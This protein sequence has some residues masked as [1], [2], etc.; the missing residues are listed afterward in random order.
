MENKKVAVADSLES[1]FSLPLSTSKEIKSANKKETC[2][3]KSLTEE[4]EESLAIRQISITSRALQ[5]MF[6]MAKEV[7]RLFNDSLEVYALVVGT[8]DVIED[9]II[10]SQICSHTSIHI[11]PEA[12]LSLMPEIQ[13][14]NVTVL[15]WTHSHANFGVFFSGTDSQNQ[16]TI[17]AET[18]NYM[19]LNGS[20]VKFCYG[21]TVNVKQDIFA[22]VST[23]FSSGKIYSNQ[24]K[25]EIISSPNDGVLSEFEEAT[26]SQIL[27]DN[28]R[29]WKSHS[30]SS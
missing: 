5:K 13:N 15:G 9:I 18:S 25:L 6:F 4:Q 24:A 23:Q 14:Q 30:L 17:L 28:I 7:I 10:P 27:R 8:L 3:L 20:R 26:L 2:I 21:L 22:M 16:K 11:S 19:C 12:L 1:L 29:V